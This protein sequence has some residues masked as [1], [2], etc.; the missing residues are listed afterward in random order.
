[1]DSS[2][3]I[4]GFHVNHCIARDQV[5]FG[6]NGIASAPSNPIQLQFAR[7][8]RTSTA[9]ER[10][11]GRRN[12]AATH[13]ARGS[14]HLPRSHRAQL[15]RHPNESESRE[16]TIADRVFPTGGSS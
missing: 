16:C 1:M 12:L 3:F 15:E 7:R 10:H 5:R 13:G 11:E 8:A 2:M 6:A 4:A 14:T 9:S